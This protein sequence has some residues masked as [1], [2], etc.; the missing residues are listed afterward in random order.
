MLGCDKQSGV[1][2]I[3]LI[4][5]ANDSGWPRSLEVGVIHREIIDSNELKLELLAF[6]EA[7]ES[8]SQ[9]AIDRFSTIVAIL[10]LRIFFLSLAFHINELILRARSH[11]SL[12][13]GQSCK[14]I[15]TQASVY[16]PW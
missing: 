10:Y 7:D 15:G 6:P 13:F 8:L 12:L 9:P 14:S 4:D 3:D 11:G 2:R 16:R 1:G 5:K